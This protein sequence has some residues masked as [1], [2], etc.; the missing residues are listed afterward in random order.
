MNNGLVIAVAFTNKEQDDE[1]PDN[2]HE[3]YDNHYNLPPDIALIG[4]T[5]SDP[6]MLDRALHGLNAKE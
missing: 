3:D 4:Y 2:I 5:S 6:K 1:E